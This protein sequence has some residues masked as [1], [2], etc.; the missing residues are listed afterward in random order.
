V[1]F[2][3]GALGTQRLLHRMRDSGQL[4]GLSDQ[5]GVLTRTN[6]ESILGAS[7]PAGAARRRALNLTEGV[8]ITSS[9]HPDADT[10]VEPVRY[11]KGS[12]VMGLLQTLLTDGGPGRRRRWLATLAR[13]PVQAA[14]TLG[15]RG[16]SERTVIALVMQALDNSLRLSYRRSVFGRRRLVA[17]LGHGQPNPSWMPAGNHA[18]RLLAEELGGVPG[19]SITEVF[20]APVTAHILGGAVIG[21]TTERGVV[22]PYHRVFGHDGLHVVDGAAVSANLGVN[23]ALT[24]VAL[25]ER[26]MSLWPNK[27]DVDPRPP[28]GNA[29][30]RVDAVAPR[31]PVVPAGAPGALRPPRD[32]ADSH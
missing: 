23:P 9:L 19:G 28:L 2:A 17:S 24:I 27:G 21:Q 7:V 11:G 30:R 13:H 12:N 14:R 15:L 18:V 5:V 26:A 32:R 10:H 8:A 25:A 29:Y 6:S 31:H 16:W 3:A 4:P 20:G 22:D 1:V